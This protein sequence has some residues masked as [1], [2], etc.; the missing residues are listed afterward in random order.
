MSIGYGHAR[1]QD[2][3]TPLWPL[4]VVAVSPATV[5]STIGRRVTIGYVVALLIFLLGLGFYLT[6]PTNT[7]PD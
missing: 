4:L 1:S 5:S 2:T 6:L 3:T 7:L